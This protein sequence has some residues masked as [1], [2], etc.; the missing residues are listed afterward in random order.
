MLR[1]ERTWREGGV[2]KRAVRYAITSLPPD[3]ADPTQLL[4]LKRGHWAIE[5]RLHRCKDVNLAE[6][7]SVIHAGQGPHVMALLRDAA[8]NVL[9]LAGVR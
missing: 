6:D 7:A 3:R 4:A 2:S 5:N 8:L 1:V 9:H